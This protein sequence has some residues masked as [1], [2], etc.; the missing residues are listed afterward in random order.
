MARLVQLVSILKETIMLVLHGSA[1]TAWRNLILNKISH[2]RFSTVLR[3][4][5]VGFLF[6]CSAS[7]L[8]AVPIRP[9]P[10]DGGGVG[11]N[12]ASSPGPAYSWVSSVDGVSTATG[13]KLTEV[14]TVSWVA[15][16]GLVVDL[17]LYHNSESNVG[18]PSRGAKWRLIYDTDLQSDG[19]GNVHMDWGNGN[20]YDFGNTNGVYSPPPG[21][22]D[23]LIANGS[24]I[25]SYDLIRKD[26]TDW[27]FAPYGSS[28]IFYLTSI[29]DE[30]GNAITV[31]R[32]ANGGM[33]GV[34]DPTGRQ[35]T[36]GFNSTYYTSLTD[37]KGRVF[38]FGFDGSGNMS[39]VTYPVLNG[40]S[41][42]LSLGYDANHNVTSIQDLRGNTATFSYNAA[43]NSIAWERDNLGNQTTFTYGYDGVRNVTSA[44]ATT[45]TDAN[46]HSTAYNYDSTGRLSAVYDAL[47]NHDFYWFDGDNNLTQNQDRRGFNWNNTYDGMGNVLTAADP[48]TNTTTY[49]YNA[50]NRPLTIS[51]PSG[52]SVAAT[53]DGNDNLTQVQEKNA[54]GTVLATTTYAVSNLTYG[55][56]TAKTDANNHTTHYGYDANGYLNNV[57][58]PLGHQTQW[59]YNA[60]GFQT[61]RVDAMNRTTTYTPD[62]WE[63]LVTTTYPDGSTHAFT[64]DPNGNLT[65]FA[66]ALIASVRSYDADNRLLEEDG[67]GV[68]AVSHTYDAPGQKGLL[69]TT[70]DFLGSVHTFTYTARDQISQVSIPGQTVSYGYDPDG[71]QSHIY[72][73]NG[74]R[75]DLYYGSNDLR[76][77]YYNIVNATGA[78][79]SA[80]DYVFNADGQITTTY[81]GTSTDP[82]SN[83]A[84]VENFGYDGQGHLTSDVRTG[85]VPENISYAY[86]GVGNRI[87]E[88]GSYLNGAFRYDA[89][90][91]V[92]SF[93]YSGT[94]Y[95]SATYGYDADGERTAQVTGQYPG[96][97]GYATQF[98]YDFEGNLTGITAA[99]SSAVSFEYDGLDRQLGWQSG[100]T[101]LDYQLDGDTTLTETNQTTARVNLYG[102]GLVS[103]GGE[104]LLYD[105]LGAV[106]QTTDAGQNVVSSSAYYGF[107]QTIASGGSTGNHYQWG[108]SSGYR[109]D[110][111]GP[112]DAAPLQKVGAR[113]YDPE[114]GVFLTRDAD[115][116]QKPY[117][118][119][120]G[121]PVNF[122]DSNGHGPTKRFWYWAGAGLLMGVEA[123]GVGAG[124][125]TGNPYLTYASGAGLVG[126]AMW[127]YGGD[128]GGPFWTSNK[129][130]KPP[131]HRPK[132]PPVER[133]PKEPLSPKVPGYIGSYG[134][135]Q[136]G[137][138]PPPKRRY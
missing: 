18:S 69:S 19:S 105:G 43:D 111:F 42:S 61:S 49:T 124:I 88:S 28:G 29:S 138:T 72:L 57:T 137:T 11:G 83:N 56:V 118:Y 133:E 14:P 75:S 15:R 67:N 59:V 78:V 136:G 54:A 2:R 121:D 94:S 104:T 123:V 102:N 44:L 86:D 30:N 135:S 21:I 8:Q 60:L 119:C 128:P 20:H 96:F 48:Y 80:Y 64:Y 103:S 4:L 110:G 26:Q 46:S 32:A 52:R 120:N 65:G 97:G 70:T 23:R 93:T 125:V 31:N 98:G 13:N 112:A 127:A 63:R 17:T 122:I 6:L 84:T 66:N 9:D 77:S 25:A 109:S 7:L 68:R 16:G 22:H 27:H 5:A 89:D 85:L 47:G 35:V 81:E 87:A 79:L 113:Y 10:T 126:T 37:P 115:L 3:L 134:S 95:A 12:A 41:Y 45:V 130:S 34:T 131:V 116:T 36:F 117:A 38:S 58:T 108:A 99:G 1:P 24:P 76:S 74:I 62:A 107:G 51:L 40:T 53:Y 129:G 132:P 106:R 71:N 33:L 90:D 114:L 50:H 39:S 82:A 92:T 73:P 100:G 91:E 55:L 101:G